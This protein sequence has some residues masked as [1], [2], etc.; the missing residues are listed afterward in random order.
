MH[1]KRKEIYLKNKKPWNGEWIEK[2]IQKYDYND[3]LINDKVF[4]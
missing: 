2:N 4:I 1:N 3:F